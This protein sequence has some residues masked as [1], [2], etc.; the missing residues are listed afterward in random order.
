MLHV[1]FR[2]VQNKK[3]RNGRPTTCTCKCVSVSHT[4]NCQTAVHQ[5]KS[6]HKYK[7]CQHQHII[8]LRNKAQTW[9]TITHTYSIS[10]NTK[11][12]H[13]SKCCV[14]QQ[15]NSL[16]HVRQVC[17]LYVMISP[18]PKHYWKYVRPVVFKTTKKHVDLCNSRKH[19]GMPDTK[20]RFIVTKPNTILRSYNMSI[21]LFPKTNT[22][23]ISDKYKS[24]Q[25]R[26][27]DHF[28]KKTS[29]L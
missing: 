7:T 16:D 2:Y 3:H 20:T 9:M 21:E 6:T 23:N 19:V 1:W 5:T 25:I 10:Y 8:I 26:N 24:K 13:C 22:Y 4:T 29:F 14:V 27:L 18:T 11:L 12:Q 17:T 28:R 15:P